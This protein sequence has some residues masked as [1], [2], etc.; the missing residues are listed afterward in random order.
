MKRIAISR[1]TLAFWGTL[2]VSAGIVVAC[3]SER[4]GFGDTDDDPTFVED[5]STVDVGRPDAEACLSETLAAEPVPLAMILV[6]DRSSSMTTNDKWNKA[7][8]AMIAFADSPGVIGTKMGLTLFP[9][10]SGDMCAPSSY[11]AIVPIDSL[12]DNAVLVKSVLQS[13]SAS[14]GSTPMSAGLQGGVDAMKTHLGANPNEE[15]VVILVTDGSPTGCSDNA[16]NVA[17]TAEAA[18]NGKPAIR[19]FVVGMDGASFANLDTIAKAGGGAPTA[20]NASATGTDGGVDAQQQLL[21]ALQAIRAG[22]LGCEYIL[23]TPDGSK[24]VLDPD[25]VVVNFTPGGNDPMVSFRRV[26]SA[27]D[28]GQTTGGFYYDDNANP[29]RIILCDASCEDVRGAPATASVDVVLGCI[30]APK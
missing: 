17:K 15:G 8:N 12:P 6:M 16:S 26:P 19:T 25:S 7:R 4:T 5:A 20:F 1:G 11:T 3:G 22:A 14:G 29:T 28:C 18:A 10:A 2:A 13:Q 27:G 30:M 21:D 23:P 9:P 24:G